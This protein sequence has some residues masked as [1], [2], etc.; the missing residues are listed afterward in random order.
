MNT[1]KLKLDCI[2]YAAKVIATMEI[3]NKSKALFD[4]AEKIYKYT[5]PDEYVVAKPWFEQGINASTTNQN[6]Y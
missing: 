5:T 4:L 1:Q 3:E 6:N 2:K